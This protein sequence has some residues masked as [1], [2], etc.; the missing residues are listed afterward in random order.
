M[1]TAGRRN[2]SRD[3]HRRASKRTPQ[4]EHG[5]GDADPTLSAA[6]SRGRAHGR[7]DVA[8]P[9]LLR[10]RRT[11]GSQDAARTRTDFGLFSARAA[12]LV[13]GLWIT[14]CSSYNSS[15]GRA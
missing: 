7:A 9:L 15:G 13:A 4:M 8:R 2:E 5:G 6:D 3:Y 11:D 1:L 12:G 10:H 14:S